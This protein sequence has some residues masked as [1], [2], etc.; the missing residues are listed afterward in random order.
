MNRT[1]WLA[2]VAVGLV[3]AGVFASWPGPPPPPSLEC[4]P[5]AVR[6]QLQQGAR[7]AKCGA[8]ELPTARE[9]LSLGLKLDLNVISEAE[10]ALVPGIGPSLA[11]KI[12]EARAGRGG[13]ARWEDV[14]RVPGIGA[15]KLELL[16]ASTELR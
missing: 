10:L 15:S 11:R 7:I 8:G 1:R 14:D 3:A 4:E 13:F 5:A 2:L 6:F 9:A 16:R 12:V